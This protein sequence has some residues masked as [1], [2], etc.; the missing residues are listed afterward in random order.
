MYHEQV[1]AKVAQ[2]PHK[3][4]SRSPSPEFAHPALRVVPVLAAKVPREVQYVHSA[5]S[6]F[7]SLHSPSGINAGVYSYPLRQWEYSWPEETS[8]SFL[9]CEDVDP[10]MFINFVVPLS[11]QVEVVE[12][13]FR[14]C[15]RT[16]LYDPHPTTSD[17]S[18]Q[19]RS[20]QAP[21]WLMDLLFRQSFWLARCSVWQFWSS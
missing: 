15:S 12:P 14:S 21:C 17:R 13:V 18:E 11:S 7:Q 2:V 4:T 9:R 19:W 6:E 20:C 5:K 16:G 1:S 3:S 10:S 8:C